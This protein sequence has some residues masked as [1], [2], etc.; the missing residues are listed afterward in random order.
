MKTTSYFLFGFF[1][2][3]VLFFSGCSNENVT[4]SSVKTDIRHTENSVTGDNVNNPTQK[5]GGELQIDGCSGC[6]VTFHCEYINSST[7]FAGATVDIYQGT[8]YITNAGTTNSNGDVVMYVGTISPGNYDVI[9]YTTGF[10][11]YDYFGD[12]TYTHSQQSSYTV[13]I[14]LAQLQSK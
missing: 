2:A 13:N 14:D 1:F 9:A 7:P 5:S 8:T 4:S 10:P 11:I 12:T 6:T 3:A